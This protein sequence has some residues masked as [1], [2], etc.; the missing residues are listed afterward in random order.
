MTKEM[1]ICN[2]LSELERVVGFMDGIGE[3]LGLSGELVMNLNLVL[4]E[5]VT[6]I[7]RYA[8]PQQADD[9]IE[10]KAEWDDKTMTLTLTLADQGLAF[11]P[12]SKGTLDTNVNP[13]EREIGGMGIFIVKNIMDSVSYQRLDGKNVVTMKKNL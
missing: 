13:A 11:D 9:S 5:M 3:T 2:R 8:Y 7:I 12:M 1:I 4:E 6:N 10:L